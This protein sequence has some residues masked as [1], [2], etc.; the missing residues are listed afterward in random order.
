MSDLPALH[1]GQS[2]DL[3]RQC[4][5]QFWS[6]NK[7]IWRLLLPVKNTNITRLWRLKHCFSLLPYQTHLKHKHM[8]PGRNR[9]D[10]DRIKDLIIFFTL[11]WADVDDLPLQVCKIK[12]E[13]LGLHFLIIHHQ[14]NKCE[15]INALLR[16]LV[17]EL[18]RWS[19]KL[20]NHKK[21][22]QIS[23]LSSNNT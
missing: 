16:R 18:I 1:S 17:N 13:K 12:Q 2:D 4:N 19:R 3:L 15:M 14:W 7:K 6:W 8:S 9:A 21:T 11:C 23:K 10:K 20:V 5:S 22:P